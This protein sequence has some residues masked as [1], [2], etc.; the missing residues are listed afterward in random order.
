MANFKKIRI[1][2]NEPCL[3]TGEPSQSG[4]TRDVDGYVFHSEACGTYILTTEILHWIDGRDISATALANCAHISLKINSDD[5]TQVALWVHKGDV[6]TFRKRSEAN[7]PKS[8]KKFVV[9]AFEDAIDEP[10]EHSAK[11]A[12]LLKAIARKL[13][14]TSGYEK[15]HIEPKDCVWAKISSDEELKEIV[16]YLVAEGQLRS[17]MAPDAKL[18][19]SPNIRGAN[20]KMTVKGW[21]TIKERNSF[22]NTRNVFVAMQFEWPGDLELERAKVLTAIQRACKRSG[23]EADIVKQGHTGQI[24]DEIINGIK[25]ARFVVADLTFN[26]RGV[27]FESG[28]AR[29]LE[30]PVFHVIKKDFID[31]K[32][33]EGKKLHFDIRQINYRE[34]SDV[35]DLEKKLGDWIEARVGKFA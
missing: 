1:G 15:F 27:Y 8:G 13:R 21:E 20:L 9:C 31:G 24:T 34:W 32:D 19:F 35:D 26:N 11:A 23:Y 3:F 6:E 10:I 2:E 17:G 30:R 22:P 7:P 29:G 5:P 25:N 12:E 16:L 14:H 18:A 4:T 33:E 28:F